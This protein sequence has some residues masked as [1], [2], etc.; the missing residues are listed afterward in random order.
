MSEWVC[1]AVWGC[2]LAHCDVSLAAVG[3]QEGLELGEVSLSK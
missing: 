2:L 3:A 1:T